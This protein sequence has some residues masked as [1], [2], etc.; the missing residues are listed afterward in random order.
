MQIFQ[1]LIFKPRGKSNKTCIKE[2]AKN[3]KKKKAKS[4]RDEEDA[5]IA[6]DKENAGKD[7]EEDGG[8]KEREEAKNTREVGESRTLKESRSRCEDF[9]D[10]V[11]VCR[12][13]VEKKNGET[14]ATDKKDRDDKE[15]GKVTS[16]EEGSKKSQLPQAEKEE[17]E[18]EENVVA[19][20]KTKEMKGSGVAEVKAVIENGVEAH[21]ETSDAED[22]P[23][24]DKEEE[25][26]GVEVIGKVMEADS[27]ADLISQ[28]P[29][30]TQE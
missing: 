21:D 10:G 5:R 13:D 11:E 26:T 23:I 17:Q 19:D 7:T 3:K 29:E 14:E 1:K 28:S 8:R 16:E 18:V 15:T 12:E 2:T 27:Q 20:N 25:P 6:D 24:E 30:G 9:D 4:D 22:N